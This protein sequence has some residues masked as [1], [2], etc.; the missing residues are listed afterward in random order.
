M[1]RPKTTLSLKRYDTESGASLARARV[2][3]F[4]IFLLS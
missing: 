1:V 3:E 2:E 4:V